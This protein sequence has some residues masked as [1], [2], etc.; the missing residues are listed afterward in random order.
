MKKL[1]PVPVILMLLVFLFG[2]SSFP[3]P[4]GEDD[5]AFVLPIKKIRSAE[6]GSTFAYFRVYITRRDDKSFRKWMNI[7]AGSGNVLVV[8]MEP[9]EYSL[10]SLEARYKENDEIANRW[11]LGIPFVLEPG[12]ITICP[13]TMVIIVERKDPDSRYIYMGWD[14][15]DT[16]GP[17]REKVLEELRGYES[18]P[19]WRVLDSREA[20]GG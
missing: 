3:E 2:C 1:G 20:L 13:A 9:G 6:G 12:A 14:I 5:T 8:G 15:Q 4:E 11:D 19:K 18:F 17:I 10:S 7:Y 16:S